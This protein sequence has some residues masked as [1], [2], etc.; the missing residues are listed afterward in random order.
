MFEYMFEYVNRERAAGTGAVSAR[1]AGGEILSTCLKNP[2][3]R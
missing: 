2:E 3:G 1:E